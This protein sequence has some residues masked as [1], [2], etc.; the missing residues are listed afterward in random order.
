MRNLVKTVII[1]GLLATGLVGALV[2]QTTRVSPVTTITCPGG[3]FINALAATGVFTC[4]T[5]TGTGLNQL[6]GDVTAGPGSGSQVATLANTAVSPGTF[7]NATV[8]FDAKGR[9]TSASSGTGSGAGNGIFAQVRS[10]TPTSVTTG[11]TTWQNQGTAT[12]A[13]A[14]TGVAVTAPNASGDNLRCRT[15]TAPATPYTITVLVAMTTT[16]VVG[17]LGGIGWS[18]GTKLEIIAPGGSAG[19]LWTVNTLKYNT[20]SSFNAA[21]GTNFNTQ[22][23]VNWIRII[24]DGTNVQTYWGADGANFRQLFTIAKASGFLGSGGYTNVVWCTNPFAT[25]IISSI[26]SWSQ[27]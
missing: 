17:Q 4:S 5:A 10:A 15:K 18:D 11:L 19:S 22:Q 26:M 12:V 2:A 3:D 1:G 21:E 14:A 13:D 9:A 27:I 25:D 16:P 7:T 24:D 20:V 23:A 6:T 8:T